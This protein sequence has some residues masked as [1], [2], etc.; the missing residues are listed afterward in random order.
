[1]IA[2]NELRIGNWVQVL[3]IYKDSFRKAGLIQCD[4]ELIKICSDEKI[5]LLPVSVTPDI[6]E[7]SGFVFIP[8][9]GYFSYELK[10]KP[11][12]IDAIKVGNGICVHQLQNLFFALTGQELPIEL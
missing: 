6:L 10:N 5:V 3:G 4:A 2:A 9:V 12:G 11:Q 1:M 7:K 8:E